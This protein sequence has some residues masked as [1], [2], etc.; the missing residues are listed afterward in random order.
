MVQKTKGDPRTRHTS[1]WGDVGDTGVRTPYLWVPG[2]RP[3]PLGQAARL[4]PLGAVTL[5]PPGAP[6]AEAP[7][8]GGVRDP[9]GP[10]HH[11]YPFVL[12]VWDPPWAPITTTPLCSGVAGPP[13]AGR[14]VSPLCDGVGGL[15]PPKL[16]FLLPLAALAASSCLPE[17]V[18]TDSP[19]LPA[20][21]RLPAPRT[22]G[23][24]LG[25]ASRGRRDL[26]RKVP[27]LFSKF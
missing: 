1:V 10:H 20:S 24:R 15:R 17:C 7:L 2:L 16:T 6:G 11:L 5:T 12:V 23:E 13:W 26:P 27:G 8:C 4:S 9:L 25:P 18:G 14:A 3:R 19:H 22:T 21:G